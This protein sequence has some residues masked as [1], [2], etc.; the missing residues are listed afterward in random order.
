VAV[1]WSV[2]PCSHQGD[3]DGG[4]KHL[5]NIGKLL[6]DYTVLQPR[7]LYNLVSFTRIGRQYRLLILARGTLKYAGM[8]HSLTS[9]DVGLRDWVLRNCYRRENQ[10]DKFLIMTIS[11]RNHGF[12]ISPPH[13]LNTGSHLSVWERRGRQAQSQLRRRLQ[14]PQ[15]EITAYQRSAIWILM[16][17][18]SVSYWQ[19]FHC[20]FSYQMERCGGWHFCFVFGWYRVR[21]SCRGPGI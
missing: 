3:D 9:P 19:L 1:L 6:P 7:R 2:T 15:L 12:N 11:Q 20:N 10:G 8:G 4:G 21:T 14:A 18:V 5:W 16:R 13:N 17:I